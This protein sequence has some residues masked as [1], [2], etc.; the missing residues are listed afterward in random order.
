MPSAIQHFSQGFEIEPKASFTSC[1]MEQIL[2]LGPKKMKGITWDDGGKSKLMQILISYGK[3]TVYSIQFVY[4]VNGVMRPSAIH[5]KPYGSKFDIV[6][7]DEQKG[8]YLTCVSGQYGKKK[9]GSITFGTNKSTYGP[10]GSTLKSSDPQFVYKFI[11]ALSFGGFHG[12]VYKS[13]LCSIGV[14]VRP[15]GLN[16]EP[17][18]GDE[19]A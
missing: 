12:S 11:P 17:D 18:K 2:K 8:E 16:V 7:F 14:Y 6:M 4:A 5:G 13:C 10:Y 1:Q 15:L 9:L 3:N 19:D